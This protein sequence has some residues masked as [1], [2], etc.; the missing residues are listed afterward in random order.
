ME[1]I[2]NCEK[3]HHPGLG[4]GDWGLNRGPLTLGVSAILPELCPPGDSQLSQFSIYC[5]GGT[6]TAVELFR[7]LATTYIRLEKKCHF[8]SY[9]VQ[10][11]LIPRSF[12]VR[13]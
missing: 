5:T 13:N 10:N 2:E 12:L 6:A 4:I 1:P 7:V 9:T 11:S 3:W 8:F